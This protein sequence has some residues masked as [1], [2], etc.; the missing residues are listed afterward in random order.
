MTFKALEKGAQ[1][2]GLHVMG[3][4]DFTHPKWRESMK[5][6]L[7]GESGIYHLKGCGKTLFVVTGEVCTNFEVNGRG[8]RIHHLIMLPSIDVADQLCEALSRFGN[9]GGDGRPNLSMTGT[10]LAEAVVELGEGC[11]IIPA[12]IWTPW[13]S[14][15]GAHGG[16]DSI[17][18]CY[19]EYAPHI[20]AAETGLSSDPPMN[21]RVSELDSVTLLSNSDSHSAHPWR[22]GREANIIEVKEAAYSEI[23]DAIKHHKERVATIEVDPAYGKYHWTGHR[24]CNVSIP[25]ERAVSMKGICPVCHKK[26]TKGVAERVEE[27]ADRADG[28]VPRG[29]Q[30]FI[31]M[32]PLCELIALI[33]GK[34]VFAAEVQSK[35]W[36]MLKHFRNEFEILMDVPK[37]RLEDV[38]GSETAELVLANRENRLEIE[39]GYDGVYGVLKRGIAEAKAVDRRQPEKGKERCLRKGANLE[40]Y[41]NDGR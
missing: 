36:G 27:L 32:L 31:R 10:E 17:T 19:G 35:Y 5:T 41:I 7:E 14:L 26:M 8:R 11:L 24:D 29:V 38:C 3:T 25:P 23:I 39:P 22:I 37:A 15:Y 4:G 9:L 1:A 6:E 21:W 40:D 34:E 2:K 20:Y 12:H 16:V 28:I 33:A 13:F 30:S 18:E